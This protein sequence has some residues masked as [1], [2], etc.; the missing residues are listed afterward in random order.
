MVVLYLFV[1]QLNGVENDRYFSSLVKMLVKH[2]ISNIS[3]NKIT[4]TSH[5]LVRVA[6]I[7]FTKMFLMAI[8]VQSQHD[9]MSSIRKDC[10]STRIFHFI[11]TP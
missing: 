11:T 8:G 3:T 9:H 10:D 2:F 6:E 1:F 4:D 7:K 5:S